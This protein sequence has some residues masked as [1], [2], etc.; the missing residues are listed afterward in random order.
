M[1][2]NNKLIND[3]DINN[4][5]NNDNNNDNDDKLEYRYLHI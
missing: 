1:E 3:N 2:N 5:I 4:D